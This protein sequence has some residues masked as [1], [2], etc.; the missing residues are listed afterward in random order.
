MYFPYNCMSG[1]MQA[2]FTAENKFNVH[3][4]TCS[5][6]L[7]LTGET[8]ALTINYMHV[9]Y[10]RSKDTRLWNLCWK[11]KQITW[12]SWINS[13]RWDD[14]DFFMQK[15]WQGSDELVSGY[16]YLFLQDHNVKKIAW[17]NYYLGCQI[18]NTSETSQVYPAKITIL[19]K[20]N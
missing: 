18:F 8:Q 14:R 4:Y 10:F 7:F 17:I 6:I 16:M 19:Q 15:Y 1:Q 20:S 11:V 2:W 9:L 12:D 13:V 5:N 3:Y